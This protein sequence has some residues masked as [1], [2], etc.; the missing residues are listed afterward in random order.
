M[1]L[2]IDSF[3]GLCSVQGSKDRGS[4]A[5]FPWKDSSLEDYEFELKGYET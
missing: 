1:T 5:L 2:K 4:W 3:K